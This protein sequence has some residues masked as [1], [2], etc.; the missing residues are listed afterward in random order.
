ME[1][2]GSVDNKLYRNFIPLVKYMK[3]IK[4]EE[5]VNL[6]SDIPQPKAKTAEVDENEDQYYPHWKKEININLVCDKNLYNKT[7][8]MPSEVARNMKV[9]WTYNTYAPIVYMSDFW[10]LKKDFRPLND[11]LDGQ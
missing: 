10:H 9:D 5:L 7:G 2:A 8:N 6:M 11:T 1:N 4:E 3:Q